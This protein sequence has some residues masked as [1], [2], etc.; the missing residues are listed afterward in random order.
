MSNANVISVSDASFDADVLGAAG[1]VLV[2]F[3]A[4]W[5]GP[6]KA[7]KP[8]IQDLAQEFGDRLTV[9]TLDIDQNNQTPYRFG[10]R[11]VPT[12]ILFDKGKVV[13]QKVGLPRHAELADMIRERVS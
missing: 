7:M 3:E 10:V 11:G 4:E 1:P 2:K 5:C 9:A 12:V 8:M 13:G 6:C